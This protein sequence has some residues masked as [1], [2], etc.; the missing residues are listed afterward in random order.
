MSNSSH[1][2]YSSTLSTS[3]NGENNVTEEITIETIKKDYPK[4]FS[5]LPKDLSA[6]RY[7]LVIDENY[8]DDDTD[9]FDAID[10]EDYNYLIYITET[11]QSVMKERGMVQFIKLLEGREEVEEFYLSEIDLYGM[12][13]KL[14]EEGIA[15][16]ILGIIEELMV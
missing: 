9:E 7:L 11:L 2:L 16:M 13:T 5:K 15:K 6:L 8:N 1:R 4:L 14:G 10:P 12:Q 3:N